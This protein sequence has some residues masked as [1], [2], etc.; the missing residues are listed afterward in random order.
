MGILAA[1]GLY[2]LDHNLPNLGRDN[3]IADDI[4]KAINAVGGDGLFKVDETYE[5]TNLI[6]IDIHPNVSNAEKFMKRLEEV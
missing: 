1:A 4:S 5:R 3:A 2:A 6:F